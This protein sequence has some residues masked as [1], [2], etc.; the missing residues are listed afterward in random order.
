A[1]PICTDAERE[2]RHRH[3]RETRC[4]PQHAQRV[5][6]VLAQF[7][8]VLGP[9]HPPPPPFVD[10][11]ALLTRS[12]EVAEAPKRQLARALRRLTTIH[13]I[14]NPHLQVERE[15]LVHVA[16]RVRTQQPA[17]PLPPRHRRLPLPHRRRVQRREHRRRVP[18]PVLRLHPELRP[19]LSGQRLVLRP[20][21]VLRR[22][23]A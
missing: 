16:L 19:A 12:L 11:H 4:P 14:P 9:E 17:E 8:E 6:D 3:C 13:Q 5:P 15:L 1:L 18:P 10:R 22:A 21:V 23:P 7:R 20:P 2:R